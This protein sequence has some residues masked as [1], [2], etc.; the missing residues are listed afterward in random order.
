MRQMLL[1]PKGGGMSRVAFRR[2]RLQETC[3]EKKN[4]C[5][6]FSVKRIKVLGFFFLAG[7]GVG[8][9]FNHLC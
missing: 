1:N 5:V 8:W 4:T 2:Y 9:W 3:Q 6:F 7:G